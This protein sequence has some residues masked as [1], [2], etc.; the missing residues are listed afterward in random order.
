MGQQKD[1]S[2]IAYESDMARG[3]RTQRRLWIAILAL[4]ASLV[5][6]TIWQGYISRKRTNS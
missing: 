2:Y 6:V 4:I 1:I 5:G 3:E